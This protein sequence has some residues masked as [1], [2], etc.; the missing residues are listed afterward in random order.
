VIAIYRHRADGTAFRPT[1]SKKNPRSAQYKTGIEIHLA[2]VDLNEN[3]LQ[4]SP[5]GKYYLL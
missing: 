2:L 3:N 4:L 1:Y 5:N